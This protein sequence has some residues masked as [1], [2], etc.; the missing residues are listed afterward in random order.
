[1]LSDLNSETRASFHKATHCYTLLGLPTEQSPQ[2]RELL[3]LWQP[4]SNHRTLGLLK[5][6][7]IQHV[8]IKMRQVQRRQPQ[9]SLGCRSA[10]LCRG[11]NTGTPSLAL[12]AEKLSLKRALFSKSSA[13]L[14]T[15]GEGMKMWSAILIRKGDAFLRLWSVLIRIRVVLE[16]FILSE[17]DV[18]YELKLFRVS[19][20]RDMRLDKSS[21]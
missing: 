3:N 5:G 6:S 10:E 11:S 17:F 1:M 18:K 21:G 9:T 16:G 7:P 15:D 4:G 8:T 19:S 14:S 20:C 2:V 13:N 12:T